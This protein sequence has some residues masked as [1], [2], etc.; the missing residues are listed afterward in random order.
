MSFHSEGSFEV[1]ALVPANPAPMRV[2]SGLFR[3]SS[4]SASTQL[5]AAEQKA[6]PDTSSTSAGDASRLAAVD[7]TQAMI[8]FGLDGIVRN[9]NANF[10]TAM[11][12]AREEIVGKH[13]RL[14]CESEF[15][16]SKDYT[17][18]WRRLGTGESFSG[19]YKRLAR[20][21]REIWIQGSYNPLLDANGKPY[22]VVKACVDVTAQV[23]DRMQLEALVH[24]AG[25]VLSAMSE[26]DLTQ[27]MQGSFDGELAALAQSID[28]TAAT[29]ASTLKQVDGAA[30]SVAAA[31][32]QLSESS[33]DLSDRTSEQVSALEETAATVEE[34]TTSVTRNAENA[35][36]ADVLGRRARTAAEQSGAVMNDALAAMTQISE[37]GRRIGEIT[38]MLDEL[39]FQT[40]ILALNAAVEAARAGDHG[41]GFAVVADEVRSLAL[42]S[43]TASQE[44]GALID[45]TL[46][47]VAD[48]NRLVTSTATNLTEIVTT[49]QQVTELVAQVRVAT[50]EQAAGFQQVNASIGAMDVSNQQNAALVEE[51]SAASQTLEDDARHM[52]DQVASFT[53]SE[54]AA[55]RRARAKAAAPARVA[56]TAQPP[57][58]P[59]SRSMAAIA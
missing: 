42:R 26:G 51:L 57:V 27:R 17:D 7:R 22:G 49:V 9:A 54:Y 55:A 24:E 1:D 13:H 47:R 39:A 14:F 34:L 44:I 10:L 33:A 29:L 16:R 46:T 36:A 31:V 38:R 6:V 3:R 19:T 28:T 37:S 45:E 21:G 12:Y 59:R 35:Q 56:A 43:A 20:G 50:E 23:R 30:A 15:A 25:R 52:R 32:E 40:N 5:R 8:E 48:G 58:K 11:G 4:A 41:R 18:F 53:L 2:L